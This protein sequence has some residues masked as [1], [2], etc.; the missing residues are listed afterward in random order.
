M[1]DFVHT[2]SAAL[3]VS[4]SAAREGVLVVLDALRG[5][6]VAADWER[7]ILGFPEVEAMLHPQRRR[8]G[9]VISGPPPQDPVGL[10]RA[11]ADRGL[12]N[13][14]A[15]RLMRL[16]AEHLERAVGLEW[17]QAVSRRCPAVSLE[18][19]SAASD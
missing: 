18:L 7:L 1:H 12:G 4:E 14:R 15:A 2:L 17:W 9:G 16:T 8:L 6:A 13:E 5:T 11:V 3:S 19:A 10:R